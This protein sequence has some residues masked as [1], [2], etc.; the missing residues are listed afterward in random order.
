MLT[1]VYL[2]SSSLKVLLFWLDSCIA[3]KGEKFEVE[4]AWWMHLEGF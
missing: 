1:F 2:R 3:N 4:M